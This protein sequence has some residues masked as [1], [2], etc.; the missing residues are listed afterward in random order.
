MDPSASHYIKSPAPRPQIPPARPMDSSDS[1]YRQ[2]QGRRDANGRDASLYAFLDCEDVSMRKQKTGSD[3]SDPKFHSELAL[4][5]QTQNAILFRS[6]MRTICSNRE[7]PVF[8]Y[9][10]VWKVD[11]HSIY[12]A[13]NC[14]YDFRVAGWKLDWFR[15]DCEIVCRLYQR[16]SSIANLQFQTNQC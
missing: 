11:R 2:A 13:I 7:S 15:C 8:R 14:H 10:T 5:T 6:C 16:D 12:L 3:R 1:H 4:Q 9:A